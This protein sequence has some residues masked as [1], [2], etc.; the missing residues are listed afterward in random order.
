VSAQEVPLEAPARLVEI[1][2][3]L[4]REALEAL[5][6]TAIDLLDQ[7]DGDADAEPEE[8]HCLAGDEGCGAFVGGQA[9]G[10]HWG[11]VWEGE[12][13]LAPA[14]AYAIDQSDPVWQPRLRGREIVPD[15]ECGSGVLTRVRR[16]RF[17][18]ADN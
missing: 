17:S 1:L 16:A 6:K 11:S 8:D 14:P 9:G 3:K 10:T 13:D 4:D 7:L 2:R 5:A 18:R 15:F 12:A